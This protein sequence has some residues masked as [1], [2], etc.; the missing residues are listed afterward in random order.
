[1]K[2]LCMAFVFVVLSARIFAFD[3]Q[4]DAEVK[5]YLDEPPLYYEFYSVDL[6]DVTDIL[7]LGLTIGS[8]N[9]YNGLFFDCYDRQIYENNTSL[10][11]AVKNKMK[12]L[13]ANVC[14]TIIVSEDS[15]TLIINIRMPNAAY[16]TIAYEGWS[17]YEEDWES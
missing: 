14:Y 13:A 10:S 4:G 15:A 17:I 3:Y 2:K 11:Q 6:N 12:Q 9:M 8:W 1:M 5:V 7:S 16:T